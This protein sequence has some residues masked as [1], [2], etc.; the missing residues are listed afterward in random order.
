MVRSVAT[1]L[2]FAV[3]AAAAWIFALSSG[4]LGAA[5]YALP[6]GL[7]A[8]ALG[9]GLLLAAAAR[10]RWALLSLLVFA[11]VFLNILFRV[12]EYGETGL[13]AQNGIKIATWLAL[14]GIAALN[15]QRF[16]ALVADPPV[17]LFGAF[18]AFALLSAFWSPVP[19]YT[20]AC[21]VGLLA[22]LGFACLVAREFEERTVLRAL[23]WGLAAFLGVTWVA[24]AALPDFAWLP[25]YGDKPV[26]RL[27]G[28]SG[29]PNVLAK[30]VAVFLL[31][32]VA[33]RARGHLGRRIGWG[34]LAFGLTTIFAT[35]SRTALLAALLAWALVEL[36]S[37]RLLLA[38]ATACFVLLGLLMLVGST[39]TLLDLDA[40]LGS[41][42][43]T[44]DAS[45]VLTLT[46]RT[47]LWGFVWEKVLQSPL[48]GYGFNA[49]EPIV[50]HEWFGAEDAAVG[51]HNTFLQ[52][53]FTVGFVGTAPLV[54]AFAVLVHRWV[55][56]PNPL[57]DLFT[58]Y[59]L[60]AGMTEVEIT[61]IPVLLTLAAFLAIALDAHGRQV[62]AAPPAPRPP[63]KVFGDAAALKGGWT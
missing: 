58:S 60:V 6:F 40:L 33:A 55:T 45:E 5:T 15:L 35:N 44:G 32:V 41:A 62:T 30:Q 51:A 43:R 14:L 50:T 59:L 19:M 47:E 52:A 61:S 42:S 17:A 36:R 11:A 7:L 2:L 3:P 9:A 23:V 48:I 29:H 57:R 39:G 16:A 28:V 21:A 24:A 63:S 25:P 12:R 26:Y 1:V 8:V 37:R 10:A 18:S 27:Q 46:G 13:D 22:Y 56:R 34:L 20:A 53:L 49:F 4:A 38:A 54:A 31:L